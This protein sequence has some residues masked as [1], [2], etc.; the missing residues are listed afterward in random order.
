MRPVIAA[1]CLL[2]VAACAG[3]EPGAAPATS[4]VPDTLGTI[5]AD[6]QPGGLANVVVV[7]AVDRLPMRSAVLVGPGDQ[8]I[9]AYS[10]DVTPSP[11]AVPQPGLQVLMN[12]PGAPQSVTQTN[13]MLSVALIELPNPVAYSRS[14][15]DWRV[16]VRLGDPGA[17]REMTLAAPPPPPSTEA[18]PP[19]PSMTPTPLP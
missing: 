9:P 17:G 14:W 18:V 15:R 6:F 13:T 5:S 7:R 10:L 19:M 2:L 1:G 4:E 3:G 11:A 8:S 16:L 12:T